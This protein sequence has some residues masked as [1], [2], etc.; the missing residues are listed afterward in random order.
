MAARLKVLVCCAWV[1]GALAAYCAASAPSASAPA[2]WQAGGGESAGRVDYDRD[3]RPIL[4]TSCFMCHSGSKPQAQLRLDSREGILKGGLSGPAVTPGDG[5]NSLLV[6]RVL[7]H[8]DMTRMPPAG[9]PLADQQVAVLRA[10]IDQGAGGPAAPAAVGIEKHWAYV[11]PTRPQPPRVSGAA[12]AR[13]PIDSFVLARLERET[14]APSP[15]APREALIRRLSLDLTGLP[16][17]VAEVDAFLAD[18]SPDAYEKI[19]ERLLGSPHYGERWA[20]PWLDLARYADTNGYEKDDRRSAWKYRDWVIDALNRDMPFDQFTV[21]QIAGDMLPNATDDQ[22]IATGFNRNTML[23]EEGGVDQMEAR[24]ETIVDRVGTTATVWLGSTVACAQCHNHKFD[25]FSQK[26]F[27]KLFA[28]FESTDYT[29]EGDASIGEQKLVEPRLE[30]PTPEQEARRREITAEMAELKKRLEARGPESEAEQAAWERR[31]AASRAAWARLD[32]VRL[33][34]TGGATL[35]ARPDGSVVA[36]GGGDGPVTYTIEARTKLQGITGLRLE[37]LADPALPRGGPGRDPYGN[38][39]LTGIEVRVAPASGEPAAAREVAFAKAQADGETWDTQAKSL[40]EPEG[41]GWGIDATRDEVRLDRQAVLVPEAPFGSAGESVVLVKLRHGSPGQS[42]GR[43][44]LSVTTAKDPTTIVEVPATLRPAL[45]TPASARTEKQRNELARHFQSVA[46]SLEPARNRL[47]ELKKAVEALNIPSTL[48]MRE[49]PTFERPST[50]F[51]VRGSYLNKGERVYADVP[52]FLHPMPASRM[53]N[54]LG[55]AYWLVDPENPLVA[56]VTV[57][58]IWEQYFGRGIVETSEDFG[59]QGAKPS[60]PELLDWLATEFMERGWSQKA[61]HRL[62][63]TSATYRQSSRVT[64]ELLERDPYNRLLA[65][66]PRFRVEAEM[67]RDVGLAA[68]GLLNPK[69]GGPSVFPYQPE[70][71]WSLP[72]NDD[73]WVMSPQADRYRRGLYTF[74]RRTSPYPSMVAF[75]AASREYCTPRRVR[76]NTPLQALTTLN[77]PA[78]F[79]MAKALAKRMLTETAGGEAERAAYGFRLCTARRPAPAEVDRLLALYRQQLARYSADP[80]A[81]RRAVEGFEAAGASP[82]ELATW[83]VVANVL[84]NLDETVTKE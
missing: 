8:G 44:R 68:S 15:E 62:I 29:F 24:W 83:T 4:E 49:P 66:G 79:E 23:N 17:T 46:P 78:F 53:P 81:A 57:N 14:L 27:Y 77:D 63:V 9:D 31:V 25:P 2:A 51:R 26:D 65:R 50:Y 42:I 41:K 5:A 34:A 11:K 1:V 20:R 28:F 19:V 75:D 72:Y 39:V 43:F 6:R 32:A 58:R 61:I 48:V 60:H 18:E 45:D 52:S 64:P 56:R 7:G 70:G 40:L 38:F 13:N 59:T 30:T 35:E 82:A 54:R 47:A 36:A 73:K 22:R 84:L 55:L 74:W 76:T 37:A 80:E 21:E 69:V 33:D 3:V 10:W 67:V 16:P 12:W 71:I